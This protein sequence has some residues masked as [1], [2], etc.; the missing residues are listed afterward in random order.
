MSAT[1]TKLV[2]AL[3]K[4]ASTPERWQAWQEQIKQS[5]Y[6]HQPIRLKDKSRSI[7]KACGNRR[8]SVC[9][10]C[11]ERYR[12]D[13]WQL[14]AAGLKGGKGVP[15][16][17]NTHPVVFATF[18]APSFGC[19][20]SMRKQVGRGRVCQQRTGKCAHGKPLGCWQHHDVNDTCIGEPLCSQ[21]FDYEQAV[22][23][24][25]LAPELWRRTTIYIKR[26]LATLAGVT[27]SEL[28]RQVRLSYTKVV[29]YQRR[30]A[31]HYHAVIR[32]D[33]QE[34]P[35]DWTTPPLRYTTDLLVQAIRDTVTQ[36]QTPSPLEK[37]QAIRWGKQLDVKPINTS[38]EATPE[39]AISY[40]AKYATKAT[41][42]VGGPAKRVTDYE[43]ERLAVSK[44]VRSYLQAAWH[45]GGNPHLSDLKLRR[46]AHTLGYRGH[47][48][49][50]SRRYSTTLTALRK[51]RATHRRRHS[52]SP[53]ASH[54]WQYN[55]RGHYAD[56][57]LTLTRNAY[58]IAR[59]QR[60]TVNQEIRS[61]AREKWR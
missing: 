42:V 7:L 21:C 4:K 10:P 15:A 60:R 17:I 48:T 1:D 13:T 27:Q 47:C 34:E 55:G 2:R 28:H 33:A 32:L 29:E 46:W 38:G 59:E 45:L 9:P 5:N 30:G 40:I 41:E 3:A 23:W 36:V 44:H 20:H 6:C 53:S 25:A 22:I 24:N 12:A 11:S 52:S 54:N 18:T 57:D 49:T 37:N 50:K 43:I 31:I 14:V 51:A 56:G 58:Q 61:L 39:K 16:R 19:V 8:E 35:G 26:A